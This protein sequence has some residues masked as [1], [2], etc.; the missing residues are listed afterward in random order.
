MTKCPPISS[1]FIIYVLCGW[2]AFNWNAFLCFHVFHFDYRFDEVLLLGAVIAHDV[3]KFPPSLLTSQEPC[4]TNFP[5]TFKVSLNSTLNWKLG[6]KRLEVFLISCCSFQIVQWR[7]QDLQGHPNQMSILH[8]QICMPL[9]PPKKTHSGG[10]RCYRSGTV[11]SNTVNS[12]FH[13]IRSLLEI[14]ARFL[15]FHV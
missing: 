14:F 7:I 4:K 15:S 8:A 13:L 12:K 5:V 1:L 6:L 2:C 3:I 9:P 10:D 11:N